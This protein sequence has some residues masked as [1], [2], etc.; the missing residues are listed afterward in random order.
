MREKGGKKFNTNWIFSETIKNLNTNVTQNNV[1]TYINYTTWLK[2]TYQIE[3]GTLTRK[4]KIKGIMDIIRNSSGKGLK[5]TSLNQDFKDVSH[6]SFNP[7]LEKVSIVSTTDSFTIS[8]FSQILTKKGIIDKSGS[9]TSWD[10][11]CKNQTMRNRQLERITIALE[12]GRDMSSSK[13]QSKIINLSG[14]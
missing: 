11:F 4:F 13:Y 1:V 2:E 3:I 14:C 8:L 6:P 5:K 10:I 9:S 7:T 12:K